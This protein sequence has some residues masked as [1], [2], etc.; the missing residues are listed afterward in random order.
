VDRVFL[1]ANVLS[2]AAYR[3]DSGLRELWE[4]ADA[5]L[6]TSTYALEEASRNL[7][8]IRPERL[9]DLDVLISRMEVVAMPPA[10]LALPESVELKEKDRPI[11]LAAILA[12]AT[13]LLTGDKE[14]FGALFGTKVA[15]VLILTPGEYLRSRGG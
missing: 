5:V 4:R 3:P 11:L 13:H 7:S 12:K 14:D 9:S 6:I 2:S 15:G 1:D 10:S 8:A